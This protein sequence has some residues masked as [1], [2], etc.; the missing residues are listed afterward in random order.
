MVNQ[1]SLSHNSQ[2]KVGGMRVC[3]VCPAYHPA[4]GGIGRQA[5]YLTEELHRQGIHLFVIAR[6]L[7]GI[8][9]FNHKVKIYLKI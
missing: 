2:K 9:P 7:K 3:I 5:V 4:L 8:L 6:R 1:P